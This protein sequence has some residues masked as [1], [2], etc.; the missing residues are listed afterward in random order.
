MNP[1]AAEK[2]R[3]IQSAMGDFVLQR[4]SK[5]VDIYGRNIGRHAIFEEWCTVTAYGV[6]T[7]LYQQSMHRVGIE[8][9]WRHAHDLTE[10]A[11]DGNGFAIRTWAGHSVK[12]IRQTDDAHRHGD[13][14]HHE[15][16][17]IPRTVPA[18]VMRAHDFR[19]A[20]PGELYFTHNLVAND[21]MVGHLAKLFRLERS[22]FAKEVFV[23]CH[24]A[25][26]VQIS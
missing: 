20:R 9:F 6:A 4:S 3:Q 10:R 15:S 18:L 14:F 16:V 13:V 26:I 17:G 25:Y 2:L 5:M 23:Y 24:F 12:S 1:R 8:L 7:D 19:N 21:S 22:G 11:S